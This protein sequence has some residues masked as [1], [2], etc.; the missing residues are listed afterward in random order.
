MCLIITLTILYLFTNTMCIVFREP[1]AW[2]IDAVSSLF[3]HVVILQSFFL[4]LKWQISKTKLKINNTYLIKKILRCS[5]QR[6]SSSIIV[7]LVNANPYL[8][9]LTWKICVGYS[10]ISFW[11]DNL[12]TMRSNSELV[13]T[14][15]ICGTFTCSAI[16]S[17]DWTIS[18]QKSHTANLFSK[19]Y[20][21]QVA[22]WV[23]GSGQLF[24]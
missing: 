19:L 1:D 14:F 13:T 7:R 2:W 21:D 17:L 4:S 5:K 8:D 9:I 16:T 11:L 15:V 6:S 10:G 20:S 3:Y 24:V 22:I 23:D 12:Y 18:V